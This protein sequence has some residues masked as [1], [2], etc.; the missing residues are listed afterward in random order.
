MVTPIINDQMEPLKQSTTGLYTG[1]YSTDN[2]SAI[3]LVNDVAYVN[4]VVPVWNG[5]YFTDVAQQEGGALTYAEANMFNSCSNGMQF[6]PY[7]D[8][9][10]VQVYDM[11]NLQI[12]EYKYN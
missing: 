1:S 2:V 8:Q 11:H 4:K 10:S 12:N 6:P 7:L 3:R 9:K 5:T